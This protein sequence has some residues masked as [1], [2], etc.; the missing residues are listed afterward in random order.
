M[1]D[2]E[3]DHSFE[4]LDLLLSEVYPWLAGRKPSRGTTTVRVRGR[5]RLR[6]SDARTAKSVSKTLC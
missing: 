3:G 5:G 4:P 2:L 1:S 6:P